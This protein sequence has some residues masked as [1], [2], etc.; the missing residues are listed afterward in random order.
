MAAT[1]LTNKQIA[2]RL[3]LSHRTIGMHLHQIHSELGIGSRAALHD[4]LAALE[5]EGVG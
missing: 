3:F 4:T 5:P 2:E 1:G